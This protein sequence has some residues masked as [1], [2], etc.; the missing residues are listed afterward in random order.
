MV[1]DMNRAANSWSSS[2]VVD[3]SFWL[4]MSPPTAE[5]EKGGVCII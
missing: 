3:I 1:S 2:G 5:V 4:R